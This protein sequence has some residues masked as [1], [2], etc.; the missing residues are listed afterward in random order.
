MLLARRDDCALTL[1]PRFASRPVGQFFYRMGQFPPPELNSRFQKLNMPN[2]EPAAFPQWAATC[3]EFGGL[4]KD[5]V[6]HVARMA[7]TGA[8]PSSYR[9]S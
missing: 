7:A 9:S 1:A 4:L 2:V 8:P 5:A 6:E 3:D